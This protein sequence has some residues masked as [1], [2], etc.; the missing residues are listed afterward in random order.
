M[1]D[2]NKLNNVEETIQQ[3]QSEKSLEPVVTD[4][5]WFKVLLAPTAQLAETL[6]VPYTVETE[7]WDYCHSWTKLTLAHHGPRSWNPAPCEYPNMECEPW[8]IW[9]SHIDLDTI[10]WIMAIEWQK[11]DT[12]DS[13]FW[14]SVAYIDVNWPHHMHELPKEEQDKL[15]A[16]LARANKNEKLRTRYTDITDVTPV[17]EECKSMLLKILDKDDPSNGEIISEWREREKRTTEEIEWKLVYESDKFRAFKTDWVF[18]WAAYYSPTKWKIIPCTLTYN[19][20]F[21]SI[22]LAFCD[23]TIP[24]SASEIM[25]KL[26]WPEAGWRKTIAGSSRGTEMT[27]EDFERAKDYLESI[28]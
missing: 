14:K 24:Y 25:Q 3:L 11:N 5:K 9:I 22:T 1:T 15:I 27:I 26:F 21:K 19:E 12:K 2:L 8:E 16:Y 4:E 28:L 6:D 17:I 23:E 20:K 18:C 7:Y 10:W 13:E